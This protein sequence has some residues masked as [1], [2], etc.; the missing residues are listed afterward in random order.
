MSLPLPVAAESI[1]IDLRAREIPRQRQL[2][3]HGDGV[4]K[5][6]QDGANLNIVETRLKFRSRGL[7]THIQRARQGKVPGAHFA[8][9]FGDHQQTVLVEHLAAHVGEIDTAPAQA[10]GLQQNVRR[11]APQTVIVRLIEI[12]RDNRTRLFPLVLPELRGIVVRSARRRRRKQVFQVELVKLQIEHPFRLR[13]QNDA[14]LP[15]QAAV[16]RLQVE[17]IHLKLF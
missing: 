6:F 11:E 5:G 17:I 13:L 9:Q 14:R 16:V 15:F 3:R 1:S 7:F 8:A 10:V 2:T 4:V 12:R